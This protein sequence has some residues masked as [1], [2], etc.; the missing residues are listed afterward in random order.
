MI[1]DGSKAC[2]YPYFSIANGCYKI[3]NE[4]RATW[5]QARQFCADDIA[6]TNGT[7]FTGKSHLA[8]LENYMERSAVTKYMR[9]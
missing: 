9:V 5:F 8:A 7:N 4:S 3:T 1:I 6:F 2:S